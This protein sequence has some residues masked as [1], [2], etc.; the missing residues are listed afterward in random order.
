V[1]ASASRF[2][3]LSVEGG[4]S[5]RYNQEVVGFGEFFT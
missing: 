1:L 2:R 3:Q 5:T 4:A